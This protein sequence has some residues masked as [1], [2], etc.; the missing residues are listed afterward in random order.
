MISPSYTKRYCA[1]VGFLYQWDEVYCLAFVYS[2]VYWPSTFCYILMGNRVWLV[3]TVFAHYRI[4][5]LHMFRSN[6]YM[7]GCLHFCKYFIFFNNCMFSFRIFCIFITHTTHFFLYRYVVNI[8]CYYIAG[9]VALHCTNRELKGQDTKFFSQWLV[10][11]LWNYLPCQGW[12]R[13]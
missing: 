3:L 6:I 9:I 7:L 1:G 13:K 12:F 2:T 11:L 8:K 4:L 5:L 10:L